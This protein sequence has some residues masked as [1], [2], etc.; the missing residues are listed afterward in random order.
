MFYAVLAFPLNYFIYLLG[1]FKFKFYPV[2]EVEKNTT[3]GISKQ[4]PIASA[5]VGSG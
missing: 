4:K 1:C 2:W 5:L 3:T